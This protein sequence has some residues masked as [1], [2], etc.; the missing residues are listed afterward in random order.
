L[1]LVQI[2]PQLAPVVDG[3][4]GYA[5]A[6]ARALEPCGIASHFLV[7]APSWPGTGAFPASP[8]VKPAA[9]SLV[10]QLTAG[11]VETVLLHYVN[12]GYQ[13]R[14]CPGWLVA[15]LTE[16]RAAAPSRRLVTFFHELY[17]SGPPWRSSF[18]LE[19]VQ[20]RLAARLARASDG[21]AT[22]LSHY[23]HL[24]RRWAPRLPLVVAPVFS[25]VGEPAEVPPPAH[26]PRTLLVFGGDGNRRRTFQRVPGALAAA[27]QAFE[28]SAVLDLG[29]PFAGLPRQVSGVP[30]RALG[31]RPGPEVSAILQ[32]CYAGFLAYPA[33]YLPKS[34]IFAAYAAHGLVPVCAWTRRRRAFVP[35]PGEEPPFWD[36]GA[37][38]APT[39]PD[40]L[41]AQARAWYAAHRLPSLAAALY[42]LLS[43]T[44]T[45]EADITSA[46]APESSVRARGRRRQP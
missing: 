46:A 36:P 9:A 4:G 37:G 30:V 10:R 2:V 24:L 11:G 8:I 14:G 23:G 42:A 22:S 29:P 39:D 6:L 15:A 45:R 32:G 43:R 18:W 7:A 21:A 34:T 19:P 44:A 3:V 40:R 33:P 17:A 16:W 26:R 28:I 12:Y 27:C 1:R 31:V 13:E 5:M 25:T 20:R 38:P 41:A 35:A